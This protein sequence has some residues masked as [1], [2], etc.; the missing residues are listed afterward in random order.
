MSIAL[1]RSNS[2]LQVVVLTF[3]NY[4]LSIWQLGDSSA[5]AALRFGILHDVDDMA[6]VP[7][8]FPAICMVS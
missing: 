8:V 6:R 4:F 2:S 7:L 1:P 5:L 3:L